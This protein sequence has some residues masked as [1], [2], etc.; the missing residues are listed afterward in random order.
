MTLAA[1]GRSYCRG[2]L[3]RVF[4]LTAASV[5]LLALAP[6]LALIALLIRV[7]S[8]P[9]VF[10]RQDRVGMDGRLF[11]I[12]KFRTMRAGTS[13]LPITGGDDGRITPFGRLLRRCKADELPQLFNVLAGH[14]SLV[15]PRPELPRYVA[16]YTRQQR[17]VLEVRPGL[18]DDAS[19]VFRDEER[20]LGQV[21]PESRERHYVERILPRK[22]E[23]NLAS[24]ERAGLLQDLTVLLKTAGTIFARIR[25]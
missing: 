25:P 13:G 4:D 23:L 16:L 21:P 10:F 15:G 14:M 2:R 12:L 3:K 7:S 19:L 1:R 17:R 9:P 18:T 8:G 20:I 11:S 24:I 22:L 6:F 5:A